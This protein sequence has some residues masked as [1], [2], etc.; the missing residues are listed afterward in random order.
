MAL[1]AIGDTHLSFSCEKPMDVF[2]GW[3]NYV[4]RLSA[5][6]RARV[7]DG[8]TVV[9][10]GDISWGMSLDEVKEDFAFL[11]ALPGEKII[12]K[13][14][15]DYWWNTMKKMNTFL[16]D[17]SFDSIK[18]LF[19]NAYTAQGAAIC[20]TRGWFFD[21]AGEDD[22]KVVRRE[23]ERLERSVEAAE[24][25]GLPVIAFLHY[26][27]VCADEVCREIYDVI[28]SHGIRRCYFGHLHGS[29]PSEYAHTVRDGCE[30]TLVS[31]DYTGFSPREIIVNP[32][33]AAGGGL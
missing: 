16:A 10:P 3:D 27:P 24:S 9:I 8:D 25:T 20:G 1:F 30:F 32:R 2:R 31:A 17:N 5:N 28:I 7:G 23:A 21:A 6:W 19:N 26:P 12:L 11:N 4:E 33:E 29:I 14:N 18:L 13:G 15:H 22:M